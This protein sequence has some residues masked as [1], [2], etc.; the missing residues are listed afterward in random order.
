MLFLALSV[1]APFGQLIR[2]HQKTIEVRKWMPNMKLPIINLLIIENTKRLS[3]NAITE[4]PNG[5]ITAIVDIVKIRKWE[6][7]DLAASCSNTFEE[8]WLAWEFNNVR[9]VEYPFSVPAKLRIYEVN[10]NPELLRE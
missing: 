10:I 3:G 4:D 7:E 9:R 2:S 6:K 1:I 5:V 8:G